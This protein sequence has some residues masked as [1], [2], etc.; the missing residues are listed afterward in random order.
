MASVESKTAST[1]VRAL[2]A[3]IRRV[4][5]FAW[6]VA[7]VTWAIATPLTVPLM[8]FEVTKSALKAVFAVSAK[9]G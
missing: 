3:L 4:M 5:V 9:Y 8:V 2:T 7:K 6:L 1:P